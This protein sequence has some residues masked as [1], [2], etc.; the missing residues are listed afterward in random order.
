MNRLSIK[1]RVTLWYA[2]LLILIC[3]LIFAFM[4]MAARRTTYDYSLKTLKSAA[5]IV[6]DEM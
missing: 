1:M 4:V 5:S 3:V 6:M 2:L